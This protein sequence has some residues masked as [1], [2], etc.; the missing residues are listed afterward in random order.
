MSIHDYPD[1]RLAPKLPGVSLA[2]SDR[3]RGWR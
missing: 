2:M 3:S 1:N